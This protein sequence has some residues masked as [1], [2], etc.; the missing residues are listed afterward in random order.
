MADFLF[1]QGANCRRR[2]PAA[3]LGAKIVPS[4][5][6]KRLLFERDVSYRVTFTDT[7]S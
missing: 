5:N 4:T 1:R 3:I 2:L 7:V 6:R